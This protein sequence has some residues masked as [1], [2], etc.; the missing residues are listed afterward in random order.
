MS[1][2]AQIIDKRHDKQCAVCMLIDADNKDMKWHLYKEDF[3]GADEYVCNDCVEG[4]RSIRR[5]CHQKF[6]NP[7]HKVFDDFLP[8]FAKEVP[9]MK[10]AFSAK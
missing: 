8:W 3:C 9:G 5:Q 2:R 6:D 7:S 10:E 1:D 4:V